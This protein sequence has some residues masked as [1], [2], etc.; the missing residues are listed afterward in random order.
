M[1]QVHL[2]YQRAHQ[3][4][5]WAPWCFAAAPSPCTGKEDY[6]SSRSGV[7][8]AVEPNSKTTASAW[9]WGL[10]VTVKDREKFS[11]QETVTY[12]ILVVLQHF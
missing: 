11:E 3:C 12:R 7:D 9:P 5:S 4:R 2:P 1:T 8:R 6:S 10:P